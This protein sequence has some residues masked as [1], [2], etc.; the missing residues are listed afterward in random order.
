M[1]GLGRIYVPD[2]RDWSM[3]SALDKIATLTPLEQANL[4]VQ[5]SRAT[6]AATKAWIRIATPLIEGLV[7]VPPIPPT[8]PTPPT[9]PSSTVT[10]NDIYRLDQGQ[11]SHCVGFGWTG[12]RGCAPTEDVVTNADADTAY[13]ACKVI[14]GDPKAETGS[15]VRSGAKVMQNMGLLTNYVFD[16]DVDVVVAW[17]QQHGPVVFGSNW[18]QNMFNPDPSGLVDIG[19][20]LAGGHCYLGHSYNPATDMIQCRNSWGASWGVNGD[21]WIKRIDMATLLAAQGEACAATEVYKA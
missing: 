13:Y 1:P 17:I 10:W 8:P 18:N 11:T 19:G 4:T 2:A 14:D 9:P 12:W 7:P 6:A 3:R 20:A 16:T 21:F 5:S 15:S